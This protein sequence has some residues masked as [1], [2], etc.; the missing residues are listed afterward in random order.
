MILVTPNGTTE[1][2]CIGRDESNLEAEEEF[3]FSGMS[4][5]RLRTGCTGELFQKKNKT[6]Q[7]KKIHF[8]FHPTSNLIFFL[9]FFFF[10]FS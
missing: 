1:I 3:V 10:F 7:T 4:I 6:K 2:C 5:D 8:W 9:L